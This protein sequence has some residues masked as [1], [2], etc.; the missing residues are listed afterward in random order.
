MGGEGSGRKPDI[1]KQMLE[2][3]QPVGLIGSEG[4]FLPNYS[5][6]Q[7]GALK[8]SDTLAGGADI[9]VSPSGADYQDIQTALNAVPSTGGN[10]YVGDGTYTITSTLLIKTS[11]TNIIFSDGAKIQCDG[12]VVSPLIK[13]NTTN[14]QSVTIK[15]GYWYNTNGTA[16]GTAFD[17]SDLAKSIIAPTKIENF[18]LALDLNDAANNTFY[19]TYQNVHIFDCNNGIRLTGNPVN[20][21]NFTSIR[22][23]CK[24]GG[25]GIGLNL[26]N[27]KGNTF[28]TCDFEPAT[29]TG[30]L[31]VSLSG[32]AHYNLILDSWIENNDLNV[33]ID[34]NA[35][36]NSFVSGNISSPLTTNI[37]DNSTNSTTSYFNV[38][39]NGAVKNYPASLTGTLLCNDISVVS[40]AALRTRTSAGNTALLSAFDVDGGTYTTFATLTAN[41]TPTF[42]LSTLTTI[43]GNAILANNAVNGS[44]TTVDLKTVTVSG[45]QI[46]SI[47]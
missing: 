8:T 5:G 19:N 33:G 10:I 17:C 38:N 45:G 25:G 40:G 4:M 47:V 18:D 12:A 34:A 9:Y 46:I 32:S 14:L 15:G 24:A 41:N 31:G 16:A 44:F 27:G 23:R 6:V 21:N 43:G 39:D 1:V 20:N 26:V 7:R 22:V 37:L 3:R 11:R 35:N 13:P 29:G 2:Q 30:I 36:R 28:N 42:N